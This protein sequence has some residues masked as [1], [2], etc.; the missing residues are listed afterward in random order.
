MKTRSWP[1]T[2]R[3]IKPAWP[4]PANVIAL[5]TTRDGGHSVPPYASFNLA[6][7]VGDS[8]LA[9][10]ANRESLARELPALTR[11]Q[12]LSQV[13][14]VAVAQAG[15]GEP[16]PVADASWSRDQGRACAVLTADCLPV[17]F[18]S[19]A[20]DVVAAAHAGW[21]GL[22]AGVLENT[23]A[24]M[25]APPGQ[26]LAWL[27]PAIGPAVFEVGA[28]VRAAYL[29][30]A[31]DVAGTDVCFVPNSA[32]PGHFFADLYG[33]ARLRLG[34]VGVHHV[35]GGDL[36]TFSDASR[37]YSYR[38]EGETGRMASIILLNSS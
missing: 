11:V 34:A 33:L 22:L 14:G 29:A 25:V 12:W 9:V 35:F 1:V 16:C 6:D 21:R 5:T 3:C 32:N 28:E 27:G 2:S 4:A 8:P 19:V 38:R 7:H 17:L 20:G 13:H 18:C 30:G 36:C 37:F 15:Q 31:A 23:V 24:A 10:S 26:L